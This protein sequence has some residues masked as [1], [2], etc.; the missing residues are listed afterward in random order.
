MAYLPLITATAAAPWRCYSAPKNSIPVT[1][2][3]YCRKKL[4][5]YMLTVNKGKDHPKAVQ[6]GDAVVVGNLKAVL[7]DGRLEI[8]D[9]GTDFPADMVDAFVLKGIDPLSTR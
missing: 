6:A 5:N 9:A 3:K 1:L 8:T 2:V 4:V 7:R